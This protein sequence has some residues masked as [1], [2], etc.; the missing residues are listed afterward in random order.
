MTEFE[1]IQAATIRGAELLSW[2]EM[3]G[4]LSGGKLADLVIVDGNPLVQIKAIGQVVL[5]IQH[6]RIAYDRLKR[7]HSSF[8]GTSLEL[9]SSWMRSSK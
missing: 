1:V 4:S 9:T 8:T 6:G 5:V 7:K 3:L 2:E